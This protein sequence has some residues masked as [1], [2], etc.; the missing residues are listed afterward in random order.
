MRI[1]DWSADVAASYL[2]RSGN[3]GAPPPIPSVWYRQPIYYKCNRL[4]VVGTGADIQWPSYSEFMDF[5]LELALVIGRQVRDLTPDNAAE[6]VF[7]YMI[8]N[9]MTARDA[10]IAEMSGGL[11]PAKG[12]DFDTGNVLGPWITTADRSEEHKSELQSLMRISY[13]VFC[14]HK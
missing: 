6:A 3:S 5:E 12:K 9:D 7:G 13:A 11:G 2:R 8:F 1:I 14:L 4:S 10:Q